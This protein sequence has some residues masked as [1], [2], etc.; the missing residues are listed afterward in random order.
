MRTIAIANQKGG[1]GKTT[2]A[3]NV[4]A[5]LAEKGSRTLLVDLDAQ[6]SATTWLGVE[7]GGGELLE[8]L[9]EGADLAGAV[10]ETEIE[11]LAV[12]AGGEWLIGADRKLS[13]E[14]G[15]EAILAPG[16]KRLSGFDYCL[17][18]TAPSLA[19]VALNGLVAAGEV[20]I[21]VECRVMALAGLAQLRDTLGIVQERLNPDLAVAGIV[22]CRL[23]RRTRHSPEVLAE[24]RRQCGREVYRTA[25]R[26]CVKLS[27]AAGFQ[28][29][30][31]SYASSSNGAEDYRA[32]TAEILKR[33][34]D[35]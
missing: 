32:L 10:V 26:E 34:K 3:V 6:G 14:A 21:P 1:S 29:P 24:L 12:V 16:I 31:T 11:N 20:L 2:T 30:I 4:A 19:L 5:C 23:D 8:V 9:T 18:D 17:I 28:K 13:G 15:A 25:I 33:R 22:G 7:A 27:E 35:R